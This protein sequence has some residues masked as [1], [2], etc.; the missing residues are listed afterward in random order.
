MAVSQPTQ[1]SLRELAGWSPPHGVLSVYLDLDPA[2]RG[3]GWRI[4]LRNGLDTAVDAAREGHERATRMA[5]EATAARVADRFPP[6]TPHPGGRLQIGFVEV[7]EEEGKERW[8]A[9]Q[10][11]RPSEIVHDR[12]PYLVP[13]VAIVDEGRAR[14]IALVSAERVR[15]LRWA[16][17]DTDELQD[18]E[19]ETLELA[20][21]ERKAQRSPDPARVQ[22][23]KASGRDQYDER[24]AA[25]RERFLGETGRLAAERV[26]EQGLTEL[27]VVGE[28]PHATQ[29]IEGASPR[30]EARVVDSI[31][32]ITVPE[33]E[34]ATRLTELV[35]RLNRERERELVARVLGEGHGGTRGA[36]GPQ[37]TLQALIEG[38]AEHL[39]FDAERE[40]VIDEDG[41][42]DGDDSVPL[43]ERLVELALETSAA[44]TP[45]EGEPAE[46]LNPAGGVAALLRY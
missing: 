12:N 43:R 26:S 33:G 5:L 16:L 37:E 19:L 21:R 34:V 13:L 42:G 7:T 1:Q 23:A 18:W 28:A 24:L 25:N 40:L 46:A 39:V 8:F 30:L 6:E 3:E 22:G 15:L 36:L 20:W 35:E 4:H 31:N 29:F 45:V 17:G 14:A 11:P 38:R 44:I 9:V 41:S 27:M 10:L 2:D 32:L